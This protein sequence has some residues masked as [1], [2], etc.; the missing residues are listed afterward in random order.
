MIPITKVHGSTIN[1]QLSESS[2]SYYIVV[3]RVTSQESSAST[4]SLLNIII[5]DNLNVAEY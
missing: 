3:K 5:E 1:N 4:N 2:Y